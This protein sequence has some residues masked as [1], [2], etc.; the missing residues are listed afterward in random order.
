MTLVL[1]CVNTTAISLLLAYRQRIVLR[2]FI[3]AMGDLDHEILKFLITK[4]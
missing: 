3:L 4:Y 2:Y 1:H